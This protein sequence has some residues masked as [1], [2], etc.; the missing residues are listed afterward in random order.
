MVNRRKVLY[1][2]MCG[3]A[4]DASL[5]KKALVDGV[6]LTLCPSCYSKVMRERKVSDVRTRTPTKPKQTAKPVTKRIKPV[7]KE[8]MYAQFEV[9]DDYA[10]RIRKARE[11]LG[12]STKTLAMLVKESENTI[13]RIE[14][15]KLVPPIDLARRLEDVLKVKLLVPITEEDIGPFMAKESM[16]EVTLGEIVNIKVKKK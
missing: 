6:P 8:I 3:M 13:K 16:K 5:A 1:C 4:I 10:V 7:R 2:E 15:G 11:R 9:I 12:W 14:A